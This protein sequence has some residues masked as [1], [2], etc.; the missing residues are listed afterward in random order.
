VGDAGG[1]PEH[2]DSEDDAEGTRG[3]VDHVPGS[4]ALDSTLGRLPH[5]LRLATEADI[6]E[7]HDHGAAATGEVTGG[8][9]HVEHARAPSHGRRSLRT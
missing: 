2:E 9:R 5:R 7:R 3:G 4:C 6:L 1:V 8:V